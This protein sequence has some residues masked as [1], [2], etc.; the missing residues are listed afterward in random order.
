MSSLLQHMRQA[1]FA[2]VYRWWPLPW[3][4][5]GIS[6]IQIVLFC[7][8]AVHLAKDHGLSITWQDPAPRCSMLIYNP[9]RRWELWR[10]FSYSLVHAGIGHI[11]LNI[12]MQLFVGLP[13]EMSHGSFRISLVYLAGVLA[14]SLATSTFDPGMYLAGASGGVY[15]LIAAHLASLILNWKEDVLVIRERF[16]EGRISL[17]KGATVYRLMRLLS[18][19]VYTVCDTGFA[20]YNREMNGGSNT[21]YLAHLAGA[22]AGLLVGICVLKNR[23]QENWEIYLRLLSFLTFSILITLGILWN[24]RGNEV[25]QKHYNTKYVYFL[26]PDQR[27]LYECDYR[28]QEII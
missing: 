12:I 16:R 1:A 4:L 24:M 26:P 9:Y 8:H 22:G 15:S 2:E 23:R 18:V 3:V 11:L 27:P 14:G 6:L 13:L 28:G 17:A 7:I 25:Y 10:Y 19:L 20:M 21:G 5:L